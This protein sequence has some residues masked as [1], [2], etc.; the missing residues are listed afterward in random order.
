M[1]LSKKILEQDADQ[2]DNVK[3]KSRY[4][5]AVIHG[6]TGPKPGKRRI[7]PTVLGIV[8]LLYTGIFAGYLYYYW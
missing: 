6:A 1:Y 3:S 7:W 5:A 2:P 4:E 8:F